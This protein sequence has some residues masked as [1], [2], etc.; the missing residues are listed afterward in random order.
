MIY[1]KLERME[2]KHLYPP[3]IPLEMHTCQ[4]RAKKHPYTL[5][6]HPYSWGMKP[7]G[8]ESRVASLPTLSQ[9]PPKGGSL[10]SD[11]LQMVSLSLVYNILQMVYHH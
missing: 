4:W 3:N 2:A 11:I 10:V 7:G 8:D 9:S 1:T 5:L 6:N